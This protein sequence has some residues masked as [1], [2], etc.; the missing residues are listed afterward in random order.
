[1]ATVLNILQPEAYALADFEQWTYDDAVREIRRALASDY[2]VAKA[3][4]VDHDHYQ[5]GAEWVGPGE[6]TTVGKIAAQFAPEDAIGE[7]LGNVANAFSEPQIG[8]APLKDL[9]EGAQI[10]EEIQKRIDEAKN[11]LSNWFDIRQLQEHI[12]H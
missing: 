12:I 6:A 7:V 11:L 10:P 3:Y 4:S 1:M 2:T 5:K 8:A 9:A